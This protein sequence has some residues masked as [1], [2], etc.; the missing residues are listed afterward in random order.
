M[1][2]YIV[3]REDA[4]GRFTAYPCGL[5]ELGSEGT[6]RVEAVTAAARKLNDWLTDGQLVPIR[7]PG[8]LTDTVA[9]A[10]EVDPMQRV[11]LDAL[12]RSRR[13][14][15]IRTLAEYALECP[16]MSSIPTT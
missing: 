10:E 5:P 4:P 14:D 7:L 13:D 2:H 1:M 3:V 16:S 8:F 12:E 11:Y 6:T 15:L 9:G